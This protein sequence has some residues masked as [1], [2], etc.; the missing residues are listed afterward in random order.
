MGELVGSLSFS[1]GLLDLSHSV[2]LDLRG[3]VDIKERSSVGRFSLLGNGL[4]LNLFG[5]GFLLNLSGLNKL[6][7]QRN[8]LVGGF[9]LDNLLGVF[10][11]LVSFDALEDG[12]T[13][14][15]RS[16]T[17]LGVVEHLLERVKLS[18]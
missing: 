4:L 14:A 10:F 13:L 5:L 1:K 15:A 12:F 11:L 18:E 8:G 17:S 7:E 6:F 3:L 16:D 2:V 9:A